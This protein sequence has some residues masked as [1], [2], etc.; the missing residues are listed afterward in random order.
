MSFSNIR[1][2]FVEL[3][4]RITIFERNTVAPIVTTDP[5]RNFRLTA[6]KAGTMLA[7]YLSTTHLVQILLA[8]GLSLDLSRCSAIE[9]DKPTHVHVRSKQPILVISTPFPSCAFAS[10][11]ATII[12]AIPADY[13]MYLSPSGCY[14][15]N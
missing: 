11:A 8:T 1:R 13:F 3:T 14:D 4:P 7:R 15:F 6:G 2:R 10:I 12:E 9:N 5:A